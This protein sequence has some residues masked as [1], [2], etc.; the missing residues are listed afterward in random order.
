M[1]LLRYT[2]PTFVKI[3]RD[4]KAGRSI[5]KST[6]DIDLP[7][8]WKFDLNITSSIA[9]VIQ[10]HCY[11]AMKM[12]DAIPDHRS[13]YVDERRYEAPFRLDG[14]IRANISFI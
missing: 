4:S 13:D 1:H 12:M 10:T 3:I 8:G 9:V 7:L 2:E 11:V 5:I 14:R 6:D